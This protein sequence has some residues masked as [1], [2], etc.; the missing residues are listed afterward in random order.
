ML[1]TLFELSATAAAGLLAGALL[2]EA[3][4]LVP[5]WK[6]MEPSEFLGLHSTMAGDLFRFYAP[7]TVLGT[8]LPLCMAVLAHL[9]GHSNKAFWTVSAGAAVALLMV[10]FAFFQRANREFAEG[11]EPALVPEQL[12]RWAAVHAAR[13]VVAIGGFGAACAAVGA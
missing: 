1:M 7:I 8:A 12:R 10:Y 9:Q 13:T 2:T 3:R 6:R 11:E 5:Y 4:V